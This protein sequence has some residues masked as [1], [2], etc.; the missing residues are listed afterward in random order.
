M[1]VDVVMVSMI[2]QIKNIKIL[3]FDSPVLDEFSDTEQEETLIISCTAIDL[4]SK[5]NFGEFR[6]KVLVLLYTPGENNFSIVNIRVLN[7]EQLPG[8]SDSHEAARALI[9]EYVLNQYGK[10]GIFQEKFIRE[11]KDNRPPYF[12]TIINEYKAPIYPFSYKT[13]EQVYD[14]VKA[15]QGEDVTIKIYN[16]NNKDESISGTPERV[17]EMLKWGIPI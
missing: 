9:K 5:T 13:V 7:I 2:L 10:E 11:S 12:V 17:N 8:D 16:A 3:N 1:I 6:C 14:I 4:E 15:F